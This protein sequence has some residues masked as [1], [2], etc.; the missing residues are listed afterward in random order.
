M[1]PQDSERGNKLGQ[2]SEPDWQEG[3]ETWLAGAQAGSRTRDARLDLF[4]FG[5]CPLCLAT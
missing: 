4:A 5:Y 3:S 1:A 2:V